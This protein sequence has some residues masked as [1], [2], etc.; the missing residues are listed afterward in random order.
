MA[1][2]CSLYC[3]NLSLSPRCPCKRGP[4]QLCRPAPLHASVAPSCARSLVHPLRLSCLMSLPRSLPVLG[5]LSRN[6]LPP[7]AS[8]GWL[9]GSQLTCQLARIAFSGHLVL[10]GCPDGHPWALTQPLECLLPDL[11]TRR[12]G[13]AA[14]GLWR[15][16]LCCLTVLREITSISCGPRHSNPTA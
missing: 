7:V 8:V 15:V 14:L 13:S 12:L 10:S 2:L 4:P 6:S 16:C 11:G 3:I 5:T 1:T 9:S